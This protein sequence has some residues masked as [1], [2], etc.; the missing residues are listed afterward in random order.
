MDASLLGSSKMVVKAGGT[1]D[2][3]GKFNLFTSVYFFITVA[4]SKGA[5][6]EEKITVCNART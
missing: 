6:H 1:G 2:G 3:C 4:F 5:I